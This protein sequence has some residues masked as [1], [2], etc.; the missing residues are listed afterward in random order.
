VE[1]DPPLIAK[2]DAQCG[3]GSPFDF[4]TKQPPPSPRRLARRL[5]H[6]TNQRQNRAQLRWK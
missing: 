3:H 5:L 4:G 1:Q 6:P 2:I